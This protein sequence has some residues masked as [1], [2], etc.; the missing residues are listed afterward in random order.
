MSDQETITTT[1]SE[2]DQNSTMETQFTHTKNKPMETQ[3]PEP[4]SAYP[5]KPK[6]PSFSIWPPAQKTRDAVVKRLIETLSTPSVLSNRYGTIPQDEA[7]AAAS[8]IEEEAFATAGDSAT[9]EDDGIQILQVYSKEISKRMLES[10]KARSASGSTTT[11]TV[12]IDS[13][14]TGAP[15]VD[16]P[17]VT[18]ASS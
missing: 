12:G 5:E 4:T 18:T 11:E 10:V 8:Q 1:A 9:A 14:A 7:S 6:N 17:D 16:D 3:S 15:S 2:P 13:D